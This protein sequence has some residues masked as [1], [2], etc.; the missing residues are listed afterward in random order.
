MI[1]SGCLTVTADR[2]VTPSCQDSSSTPIRLTVQSSHQAQPFH[3]VSISVASPR[4]QED[5]TAFNIL[6][7]S[8]HPKAKEAGV[9]DIL[10]HEFNSSD[11][12]LY[13]RVDGIGLSQQSPSQVIAVAEQWSEPVPPEHDEQNGGP[14]MALPSFIFSAFAQRCAET[15]PSD[16]DCNAIALLANP[17]TITQYLVDVLWHRMRRPSAPRQ[18]YLHLAASHI[19]RPLVS[20][21]S[22]LPSHP[23]LVEA[24]DGGGTLGGSNSSILQVYVASLGPQMA[25]VEQWDQHWVQGPTFGAEVAEN[26]RTLKEALVKWPSFVTFWNK[27]F[28]LPLRGVTRDAYGRLWTVGAVDEGRAEALVQSLRRSPST[29]DT[30]IDA[31]DPAIDAG[32]V[33][34][35]TTYI[36]RVGPAMAHPWELER[37]GKAR[38]RGLWLPK[39]WFTSQVYR[40]GVAPSSKQAGAE[41]S[42]SSQAKP[43]KGFLPQAPTGIAVDLDRKRVFVTSSWDQGVAVCAFKEGFVEE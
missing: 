21:V 30:G 17:P 34:H 10:R 3:P 41:G 11:A 19:S 40:R 22:T 43:R 27:A 26:R 33:I 39:E 8:N 23:A 18:V 1:F 2:P 24:W 38:K 36:H 9:V 42:S 20:A 12:R 5:S 7:V 28:D 37:L 4:S 31:V 25:I 14:P 29:T 6:I 13:E 32:A 35:Q 16:K 15:S